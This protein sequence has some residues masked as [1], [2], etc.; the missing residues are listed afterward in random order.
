MLLARSL[1]GFLRGRLD[2]VRI[3][4]VVGSRHHTGQ[5]LHVVLEGR[6]KVHRQREDDRRV[7]VSTDLEQGLQV[8]EL[9]RGRIAADD[10]S[11]LS[12]LLGSLVLALG[13]DDLG[14]PLALGLCLACRCRCR[15]QL[16]RGRLLVTLPERLLLL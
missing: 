15:E 6:D 10:V 14:A 7:L 5:I 11:S 9:E 4:G 12:Q 13:V 3:G 16:L 8:S 2:V 1:V